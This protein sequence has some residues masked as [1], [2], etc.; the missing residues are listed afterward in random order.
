MNTF[1]RCSLALSLAGLSITGCATRSHLSSCGGTKMKI[2]HATIAVVSERIISSMTNVDF[3]T[4]YEAQS[5]TNGRLVFSKAVSG[6][7][8][9]FDRLAAENPASTSTSEI[10][11]TLKQKKSDVKVC[12]T[13]DLTTRSANGDTTH[14][15]MSR[16]WT[17]DV[18]HFLLNAKADIEGQAETADIQKIYVRNKGRIGL[19]YD[20]AGYI[21]A[22]TVDGPAAKAGLKP[23]D[24]IVAVNH[25]AFSDEIDDKVEQITG[26]PGSSVTITVLRDGKK[27]AFKLVR[28]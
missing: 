13:A 10:Q 4:L 16:Q 12:A 7:S 21:Q 14:A 28:Q 22:V 26:K 2:E 6:T 24:R 3:H 19:A 18:E 20:G 25:W 11:F 17:D 23:G 1:I 15:A 5:P 9:L 8:G 27:M